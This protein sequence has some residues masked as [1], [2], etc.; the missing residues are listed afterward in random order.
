MD[1]LLAQ[2]F[3]ARSISFQSTDWFPPSYLPFLYFSLS[4]LPPSFHPSSIHLLPVYSIDLISQTSIQWKD[5]FFWYIVLW[6]LTHVWIQV[7][8][9]T[10]KIQN[11]S[12]IPEKSLVLPLCK[13]QTPS[14]LSLWKPLICFPSRWFYL[15]KNSIEVESYSTQ[16]SEIGFS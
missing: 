7:T 5:F 4:P 11:S 1:T 14:T 13:S 2:A 12:I 3:L 15:F 9:H 6:I 10:T 16:P 8:H